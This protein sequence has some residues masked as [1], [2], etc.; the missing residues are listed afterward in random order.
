MQHRRPGFDPWVGKIPWRRKCLPTP[1][2]LPGELHRQR[3]PAGYSPWGH[4]ESDMTERFS[5]SKQR[6][7]TQVRPMEIPPEILHLEL[8]GKALCF[9]CYGGGSKKKKKILM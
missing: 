7:A 1:I 2:F 6:R 8:E 9:L 4:K 3:S 5:L